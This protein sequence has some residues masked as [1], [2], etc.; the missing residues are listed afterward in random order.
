MKEILFQVAGFPNVLGAIYG[1]LVPI[2]G[3]SVDEHIYM[4]AERLS[5]I[6]YSECGGR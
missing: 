1:T 2:K 3:Q 5:R 4:S 6:G